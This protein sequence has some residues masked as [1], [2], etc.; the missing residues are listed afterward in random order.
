MAL[1]YSF[2]I[3]PKEK[4]KI[5]IAGKKELPFTN[6]NVD[7][8]KNE[9]SKLT[10]F[11]ESKIFILN[12][13]HGDGIV[14]L[15][16]SKNLSFPEGDAWIGEESNQVLCI[17][18]ADCMPL[19]FWSIQSPK[20]VAIHSGWKG[21]LAGITEKTLKHS[22]SNSILK[23]GSLVGYLG[24]YASGLR[25]EVGEDVAFLFRKEF[26]D[27]LRKNGEDKTL[28]DLES[29]LKFRLE[30]NGIRVLLQSDK[31]CTLEK[32]SDFFSHRKKETG[33]NLNL[34]WKEG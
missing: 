25:Y 13:V 18:T 4:I 29:F 31:I 30:K 27:C 7:E 15:R 20:F 23:E 2:P 21:T 10:G 12:Q 11:H 9:I 19:F 33:R 32:N 28:L 24:P 14:D 17:K 22:F 34:I 6:L 8:Q 16:M 5:L 3:S 26:P 1:F